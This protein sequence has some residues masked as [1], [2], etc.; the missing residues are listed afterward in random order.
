MKR[1]TKETNY[2]DYRHG[3]D[4]IFYRTFSAPP[5]SRVLRLTLTQ[6]IGRHQQLNAAEAPDK[7]DFR[8]CLRISG[9]FDVLLSLKTPR[10]LPRCHGAV[11]QCEHTERAGSPSF[12]IILGAESALK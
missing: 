12:A 9:S 10:V 2:G 6:T 5:A 8:S 4:E 7:D 3:G 1:G 11:T